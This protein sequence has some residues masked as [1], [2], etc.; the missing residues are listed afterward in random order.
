MSALTLD[1]SL[2]PYRDA[3]GW[4]GIEVRYTAAVP[5]IPHGEALLRL[6]RTMASVPGARI[7]SE[8]LHVADGAGPLALTE[9]T[10]DVGPMHSYREWTAD[11]EVTGPLSLTLRAPVREI[12]A[13][14]PV[15]PLF[16]LR[17]EPLGLFGAG[18]SFIPVPATDDD[19]EFSFT[20]RW[21]LPTGTSAVSSYGTGDAVRSW[22]GSIRT[23]ER[24]LLGAGTPHV[25]PRGATDV[26]IH[27]YSDVPFD[28]GSTADYLGRI[29]QSMSDFFEDPHPQYHVL[30]RRNPGKGT[31]GTSFPHSFAFGYSTVE[32]TDEHELRTL[33]AHEMVH[34]WPRLDEDWEVA[35][36]YSEGTAE[37][38][39]LALPL[40][41]GILD[42]RDAAE[43]LSTMYRRYDAN[44]RRFLSFSDA[45]E[46]IWA[47]L[48]TQTLP[49]GRGLQYLILIEEQLRAASD[50][51]LGLDDIVLDILRTQ[52]AGG[53]V[54]TQGWL[55]RIAAV[56]GDTVHQEH[57][58]MV[59]GAAM[60]RPTQPF[61]GVIHPAPATAPE[62]DLGFDI[63]SFATT[64]RLVQGLDPASAA[65]RSG[66]R[67]GDRLLTRRFSYSSATDGSTPV[68]LAL[69][70]GGREMTVRYEPR[71]GEVQTTDWSV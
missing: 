34:N 12:D 23:L 35:G 63:A 7:H 19:Q 3:T 46:L 53:R 9:R 27:A 38:Y 14:T 62:H 41:A 45:Q 61:Q 59:D 36:W 24:C 54:D 32:D 49:Y 28:L 25:A 43:Q 21:D 33:L 48:R 22:T 50:G 60:R 42:P 5:P 58:A 37:Y 68:E 15:G 55:S 70:R 51:S 66:L 44:P 39:S 17:R 18:V 1:L 20:L 52:R 67:N 4:A 47:D 56:I 30:V 10:G 8:D 16:D 29:H 11:R 71:G 64:P 31:G 6:P 57:R 40:R 69:E 65:A 2:T 13:R 26:A